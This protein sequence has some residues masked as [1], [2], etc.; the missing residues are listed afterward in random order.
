[1]MG[2]SPEEQIIEKKD[3]RGGKFIGTKRNYLAKQGILNLFALLKAR[4]TSV[5]AKSQLSLLFT[6][7]SSPILQPTDEIKG[8]LGEIDNSKVSAI[9]FEN[10]YSSDNFRESSRRGGGYAEDELPE[11]SVE[12]PPPL[13]DEYRRAKV[14]PI[15]KATSRVLRI[16]VLDG[17]AGYTKIPSVKVIQNGVK[18]PCDACAVLDGNGSIESVIVLNPGF[19]YGGDSKSTEIEIPEIQITPPRGKN[20]ENNFLRKANVTAILEYAIVGLDIIEGGNGYVTTQPPRIV[21]SPPEDDPDWY[22]DPL[23]QRKWNYPNEISLKAEVSSMTCSVSNK[24]FDVS[25]LEKTEELMLADYSVNFEKMSIDPLALFE[26]SLRPQ[27][28]SSTKLKVGSKSF[29]NGIYIIPS[30]PVESDLATLPSTRYRAFDPIF[31]GVSQCFF[32][33]I[34]KRFHFVMYMTF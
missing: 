7:I 11:I 8:L 25:S 31:G 24:I 18:T 19:G 34:S 21:V 6:L 28:V 33:G 4:Y 27:F 17:G 12:Q 13:G 23:D 2:K 1:M 5:E 16:D 10:T 14:F 32:L 29:S 22:I 15:M 30:L 3:K 26:S 20:S 9:N